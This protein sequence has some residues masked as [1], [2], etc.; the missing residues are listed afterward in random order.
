MPGM[1]IKWPKYTRK[2]G[3]IFCTAYLTISQSL[4]LRKRRLMAE[5]LNVVTPSEWVLLAAP[6]EG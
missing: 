4:D 1:N 6:L 3:G 2:C 5:V